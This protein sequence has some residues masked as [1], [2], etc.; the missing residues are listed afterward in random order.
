MFRMGASA[1]NHRLTSAQS[2][3]AVVIAVQ[4]ASLLSHQL[5]VT[6]TA[7]EAAVFRAATGLLGILAVVAHP[8]LRSGIRELARFPQKPL[9]LWGMTILRFAGL[10]ILGFFG[11]L[12]ATEIASNTF[13]ATQYSEGILHL[14]VKESWSGTAISI[15][16]LFTALDEE[17]IFR[18]AAL[19]SLR[20]FFHIRVFI[21]FISAAS[22]ASGH[23]INGSNSM[24][25][26]FI[27]GVIFMLIVQQG[28][29]LLPA[30]TS[31]AICN[32]I[33]WP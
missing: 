23:F 26:A 24:L 16:I 21:Q 5:W 31:H 3:L 33:V 6:E 18:G 25:F 30:I 11:F 29:S 27:V 28:R 10:T 2:T 7:S 4:A 1:M 14:L 13:P 12:V 22:F 8:R 17:V 15:F 19:V 20:E 9:E 32:F